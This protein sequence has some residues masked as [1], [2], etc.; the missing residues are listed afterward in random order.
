MPP[1]DPR[2]LI[3][4][5]LAGRPAWL[6]GGALRDAARGRPTADLDIVVDGDAGETARTLAR[7]APRASSF[8]LSE[9]FGAW[10]VVARDGSWQIDVESLRG[11]SLEA[12]L[13]LRD[14]TVNA[15]AE[16]AEGGPR[17]DPLGGLRDLAEHRLRM[18]GPRAFIDDPLRVLRLVRVAVELGL[19]P[20]PETRLAARAQ[21]PGL[22]GVSPERVFV[23]L[24][25]IIDAPGAVAGLGLLDDLGATAVVLPEAR[26]AAGGGAEPLPSP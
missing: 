3:R 13:A 12:D 26:S 14:F 11:G 4:S 18:A 24:R 9:A 8:A 6:V 10:R 16:P 20:E 19:E 5:T 22:S 21:A 15:V 2:E 7:A 17:I 1:N 23:E 25:R